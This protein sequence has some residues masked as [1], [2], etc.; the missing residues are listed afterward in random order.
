MPLLADSKVE[1]EAF[2]NCT[3]FT[4]NHT[5][6][7][8]DKVRAS[9]LSVQLLPD[10]RVR[11]LAENPAFSGNRCSATEI[12]RTPLSGAEQFAKRAVDILGASLA[13]VLQSPA[14][15]LTALA[16]KL[17]SPGLVLFRQ[18]RSGFNA[19]RFSIFELRAMT[20]MEEGDS[21]IQATRP[22]PRITTKFGG[23][24]GATSIDELSQLFNVL[25]GDMSPVGPRAHAVVHNR[26]HGKWLSDHAFRHHVKPGIAGWTQ[27][28]SCCAE[29]A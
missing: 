1:H 5:K 15:L 19:K 28:R 21:I 13:L 27:L 16:I 8:P 2:L 6:F 25:R 10:Q 20:V 18:P 23:V 4:L 24:L 7:T 11:Y 22:D 14:M 17:E 26:S 12:R 3:K 29:T 9:A